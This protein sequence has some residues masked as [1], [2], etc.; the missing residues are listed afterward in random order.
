MVIGKIQNDLAT[1]AVVNG[2]MYLVLKVQKIKNRKL[3]LIKIIMSNM[4]NNARTAN[5]LEV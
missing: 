2:D 5:K 4:F 3:I 1:L